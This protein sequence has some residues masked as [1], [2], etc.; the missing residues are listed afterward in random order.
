M[1]LVLAPLSGVIASREDSSGGFS[2]RVMRCVSCGGR[3]QR[4]GS[5]SADTEV[6]MSC[7]DVGCSKGVIGL[8]VTRVLELFSNS[9]CSCSFSFEL[10]SPTLLTDPSVS[11]TGEVASGT[12]GCSLPSP[13]FRQLFGVLCVAESI[14]CLMLSSSSFSSSSSLSAAT[15]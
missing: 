4:A 10:L 5:S 11:F 14:A 2:T 6:L 9:F 12:M 8:L 3:R 13:P 15:P 7:G 1:A